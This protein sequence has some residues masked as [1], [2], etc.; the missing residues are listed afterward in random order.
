MVSRRDVVV[1]AGVGITGVSGCSDI[2]ARTGDGTEDSENGD[3]PVL[4]MGSNGSQDLVLTRHSHVETVGEL[5]EFGEG[6]YGVSVQLSD[7]GED[8][9]YD[10]LE[11]LG[12]DERP[13][14]VELYTHLD[15]QVVHT[16]GVTSSLA[17]RPD[18][19]ADSAVFYAP[20]PDRETGEE[21]KSRLGGS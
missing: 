21:L 16:S 2:L 3:S 18:D 10:G 1:I 20:V 7:E 5:R 9:Y 6:S 19:D 14:A 13:E 11:A 4:L 8:A 17:E 15:G 12:A